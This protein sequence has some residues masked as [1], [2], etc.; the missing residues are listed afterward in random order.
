MRRA[1]PSIGREVWVLALTAGTASYLDAA[2][3]LTLGL[4]LTTWRARFALSDSEVGVLAGGFGLAR[5]YSVTPD[6][7]RRVSLR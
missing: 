1:E 6:E 5:D 2:A 7:A 4:S 3:L